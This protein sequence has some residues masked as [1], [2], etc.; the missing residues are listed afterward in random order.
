MSKPREPWWG[1]V[2]N[3]IRKYP[4]YKA[5]LRELRSQKITPGYSKAGGRGTT[6]R[7][8]EAV[9]LR[10]LKPGD[11]V[12]Y[13][14]VERAISITKALPDGKWRYKLIEQYYFNKHMA[15]LSDIA[16]SCNVGEA[17]AW[18]W[19]ADFVRLVAEQLEKRGAL[20]R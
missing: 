8:T 19:H 18:R 6:H 20:I 5:E 2:K 16:F 17:T 1:Y 11:Q 10:Q 9:A 7:K 12:R 14:A 13:D 3:V 15:R 4:M